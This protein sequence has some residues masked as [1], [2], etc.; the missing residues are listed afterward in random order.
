MVLKFSD[1]GI[2]VQGS[3]PKP[4]YSIIYWQLKEFSEVL[5]FVLNFCLP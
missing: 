4:M 2:T 5:F 3:I 1:M